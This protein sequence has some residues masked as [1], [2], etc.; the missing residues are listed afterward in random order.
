MVCSYMMLPANLV[1]SWCGTDSIHSYAHSLAVSS[2]DRWGFSACWQQHQHTQH[3][4]DDQR[5]SEQGERILN[6]HSIRQEIDNFLLTCTISQ[7]QPFPRFNYYL[8]KKLNVDMDR[9]FRHLARRRLVFRQ[10]SCLL[11]LLPPPKGLAVHLN[12]MYLTYGSLCIY[13]ANQ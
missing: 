3:V 5:P 1:C 9:W 6:H 4:C 7:G 8:V 12:D 2:D 10:Q 13:S 11:T